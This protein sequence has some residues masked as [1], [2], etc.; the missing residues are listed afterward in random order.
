M[1]QTS[2]QLARFIRQIPV[3]PL[4][5]CSEELFLKGINNQI[6]EELAAKFV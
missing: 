3:L 4:I 1:V 5:A 6:E 2:H